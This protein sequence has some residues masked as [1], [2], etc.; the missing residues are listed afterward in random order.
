MVSAASRECSA[1]HDR[2]H[3]IVAK[4]PSER[5]ASGACGNAAS[6][7]A[8]I[9]KFHS[10]SPSNFRLERHAGFERASSHRASP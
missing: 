2:A 3:H 7:T 10:R 8:R 6:G 4:L 5:N 9:T 1:R